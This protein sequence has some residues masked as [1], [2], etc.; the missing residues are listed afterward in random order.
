MSLA[1]VT[2]KAETDVMSRPPSIRRKI[3]LFN[4]RALLHGYLFVGN[5]E[6]F[7]AF[8]CFCYYWIDN[9]VPFYSFV[10]TFENFLNNTQTGY[11]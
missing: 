3:H 6:C 9:G 10:L 2:E 8:F 5:F 4:L 1:M 11:N 7:T